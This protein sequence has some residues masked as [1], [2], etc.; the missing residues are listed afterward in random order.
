[1]KNDRGIE[2]SGETHKPLWIARPKVTDHHG[3]IRNFWSGTLSR[4]IF[5]S[6]LKSKAMCVMIRNFWS[7][8]PKRLDYT[9]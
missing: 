1:M 4:Y 8:N 2:K 9:W 7:G 6:E 3:M 5:M